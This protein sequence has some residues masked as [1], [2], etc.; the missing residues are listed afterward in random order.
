MSKEAEEFMQLALNYKFCRD[1]DFALLPGA[2]EKERRANAKVMYENY[3]RKDIALLLREAMLPTKDEEEAGILE[4]SAMGQE[5]TSR[6]KESLEHVLKD[7]LVLD[8]DLNNSMTIKDDQVDS[9]K[10]ALAK[11]T[12]EE[13]EEA[14]K[15]FRESWKSDCCKKEDCEHF[16][17][18]ST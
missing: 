14:Y 5:V 18:K 2:E 10:S 9:A 16:E 11:E 6:D 8:K 17:H 15:N 12:A 4:E 13:E 3:A 1:D 7:R